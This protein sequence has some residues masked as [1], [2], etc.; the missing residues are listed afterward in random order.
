MKKWLYVVMAFAVSSVFGF[1]YKF[2]GGALQVSLTEKGGGVTSIVYKKHR[3]V[4]PGTLS[5]TEKMLSSEGESRLFAEDFSDLEYTVSVM[6]GGVA[7]ATRGIAAC[8]WLRLEKQYSVQGDTLM[9]SYRLENRDKKPHNAILWGKTFLRNT[10]DSGPVRNTFFQPSSKGIVKFS[11][12]GENLSNQWQFGVPR[13]W[14]AFAADD[15]YG[16]VLLLP[17]EQV[18]TLY[19]WCSS[20][21]DVS[22]LEW[23]TGSMT[24]AAGASVN[25]DVRVEFSQ[26]VPKLIAKYD[27]DKLSVKAATEADLFMPLI[28]ADKLDRKL[29][30]LTPTTGEMHCSTQ[31]LDVE[32]NRQYC[33]SIRSVIIPKGT[34]TAGLA[35]FILRNGRSDPDA[36]LPFTVKRLPDGTSEV[37]FEVPGINPEGYH[38]TLFKNGEA[39]DKRRKNAYLGKSELRCRIELDNPAPPKHSV[40]FAEHPD[41]A[42]NGS[43][44]KKAQNMDWPDGYFW[45][46]TNTKSRKNL[47]WCQNDIPANGKCILCEQTS[48]DENFQAILSV[49]FRPEKGL[50]CTLS[51]D[52]RAENMSR[53]WI[54]VTLIFRDADGKEIVPARITF[55]ECKD[56]FPWKHITTKFFTPENAATAEMVFRTFTRSQ[57]LYVDNLSIVPAPF[58]FVPRTR[59]EILREQMLTGPYKALEVL[60]KISEAPVTPHEAWFKPADAG[61]VQLLYLCNPGDTQEATHRRMIREIAQRMDITYTYIPLLKKVLNQHGH[62]GVYKPEYGKGLE[63]YSIELMRCQKTPPRVAIVQE[64]DFKV[65]AQQSFT[66]ILGAWR[67]AGTALLFLDCVNVPATLTGKKLE[68]PPWLFMVPRMHNVQASKEAMLCSLYQEGSKRAALF[69]QG[70]RWYYLKHPGYFRATPE[71]QGG[72]TCPSYYSRDFPFWE[73]I[74]LTLVKT[75]RWLDRG[76]PET[77]ITACDDN[78]F[79]LT[80]TAKKQLAATL[81]CSFMTCFREPLGTRKRTVILAKGANSVPLP[82]IALP[83]G[84]CVAHVRLLN[85]AGGVLDAAAV[86]VERPLICTLKLGFAGNKTRC[87]RQ[88][89]PV[90]FTFSC[91]GARPK[92]KLECRVEDSNGRVVFKDSRPAAATVD[93]GFTPQ[94]PY[95]TL[96]TVLARIVRN[97][98]SIATECGEFSLSRL[99]FDPTEVYGLMWGGSREQNKM[100]RDLGFDFISIGWG[101]DSAKI[102]YSH[103]IASLNLYPVAINVGLTMYNNV[104]D[105]R[106]DVPTDPVRNPCFSDRER[107]ARV[108]ESIVKRAQSEQLDYYNVRVHFLGDEVFLGSTVCYSPHCLRDFREYEKARYASLDALNREWGTTFKDWDSVVPQ[109]LNE[110]SDKGNLS[111]WLDHKMF[112]SG[113]FAHKWLGWIID[114]VKG[115]VPGTM[116]GLSGTNEPGFA[117][118]WFQLMKHIDFLAYYSGVQVKLVHDFAMPSMLSGQWGGGYVEVEVPREPYEKGKHW[119]NLM[120]GANLIPNW[121]GSAINGDLTP[122]VNLAYYCED[123][124]EIKAGIGKLLLSAKPEPP[125]VAV[126]YSQA[127][128]FAAKATFGEVIWQNSQNGWHSLLNDLKIDFK[129][130][131]YEELDS[132]V[133]DTRVLV[134]PAAVA[135]SAKSR[136]N[137]DA[138]VKAGGL[139]LMDFTPC[140]DEH[141][142]YLGSFPVVMRNQS[143]KLPAQPEFGIPAVNGD[144]T[145]IQDGVKT[146]AASRDGRGVRIA[147]NLLM[148]SY[149]EVKLTGTGGEISVGK[150]GTAIFCENLRAIVNGILRKHGVRPNCEMKTADGKLFPCFTSLRSSGR[151]HVFSMIQDIQDYWDSNYIA[152]PESGIPVTVKLPVSGYI[153]DVRNRRFIGKG[154]TFQTRVVNALAQVYAILE[155]PADTMSLKL[156]GTAVP[157]KPLTVSMAS[158]SGPQVFRFEL[159]RPDGIS[160]PWYAA[161]VIATNGRATHTFQLAFNETNVT[162]QYPIVEYFTKPRPTATWRIVATNVATGATAD[163]PL[164]L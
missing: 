18:R 12:P 23:M 2:E 19:S 41:L 143:L 128:M 62:Y 66:D 146:L 148:S 121:H 140:R 150:S 9:I 91:E 100:L 51:A 89:K 60:S 68:A 85:A 104:R 59:L 15:G 26:N 98:A 136:A 161:N 130:I 84:T 39:F 87:F 99:S 94:V 78:A 120:R 141:G 53:S 159:V 158:G 77:A 63:E 156:V 138:F 38:N 93:I 153:Y 28:I 24:L 109:Q 13:A 27:T 8:D 115:C 102:G 117:Y 67:N 111:P 11:H 14:S 21:N 95:T 127:S 61:P 50:G 132:K 134:L 86:R 122:T 103:N 64:I 129:F 56:S 17:R 112:M 49:F 82:A 58:S 33:N 164:K 45:S 119:S 10:Q 81:E 37:L 147:M 79:K 162:E 44:E 83:G 92:D 88:G 125:P 116:A 113:V 52:I 31:Y 35:V 97:G 40:L 107:L 6:K 126:L 30:I 47:F 4:L 43:F 144:F 114:S 29:K 70:D 96:Y 155:K 42:F 139:L 160:V 106:G 131:G 16:A 118:D 157:G 7:F 154:D 22:T 74:Y 54:L 69:N 75:I 123:L 163:I 32:V 73:Y 108:R 124:Q 34:D 1:E 72:Q 71:G 110:L 55:K 48:T 151:N 101:Q 5:F 76:E 20:L 149:Q 133:P 142:R 137:I 152:K 3:M 25:F 135:L 36:P 65:N 90:N 46:G 105:Y 57:K 80:I 145:V